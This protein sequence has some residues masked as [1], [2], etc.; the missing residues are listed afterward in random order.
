MA[1]EVEL[2]AAVRTQVEIGGR[3]FAIT[4]VLARGVRALDPAA[5][6]E[7]A[8][9]AARLALRSALEA[10]GEIRAP[11]RPNPVERIEGI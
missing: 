10:A 4:D 11:G 1:G 3:L 2:A 8:L 6:D 9:A 7:K 5:S